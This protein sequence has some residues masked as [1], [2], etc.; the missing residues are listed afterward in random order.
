VI[1]DIMMPEINGFDVLR[2]LKGDPQTAGIPVIVLSVLEDAQRAF[3][4]GAA[5]YIS[6]PFDASVLLENVKALA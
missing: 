3:E 1:L 6:K 4:L 2:L 5:E